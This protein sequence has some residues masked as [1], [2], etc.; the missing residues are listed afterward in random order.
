M[1]RVVRH[2]LNDQLVSVGSIVQIRIKARDVLYRVQELQ[3]EDQKKTG[4]GIISDRTTVQLV[5]EPLLNKF[6]TGSKIETG[7]VKDVAQFVGK[8]F[9]LS[10]II[11]PRMPLCERW[12]N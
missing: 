8:R 11:R 7:L 4:L 9:E 10:F 5:L 6:G 2:K 12:R 3:L 1:E